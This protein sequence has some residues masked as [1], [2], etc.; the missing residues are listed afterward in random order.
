MANVKVKVELLDEKAQVPS[1]AHKTDTGYDLTLIGVEKIVGDVILFNTGI[2]MQ[3]SNGYYFEVVPRSSISKLPLSMANS[4]G[5]IDESYTGEVLVPV[6]V[7]HQDMGG[8]PSRITFPNGIVKIFGVRPQTMSSLA[9]LVLRHKPKL[10]QAILRKRNN[11]SFTIQELEETN[12]SDGGF[13]STD[14]SLG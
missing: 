2:S 1:R 3:P 13:G 7:H 9:K 11:C 6:R 10:F 14:L 12:R 4:V 8:D 5:I